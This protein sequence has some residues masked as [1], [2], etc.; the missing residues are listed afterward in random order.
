MSAGTLKE[1]QYRS[2]DDL[3]GAIQIDLSS[4]NADN[5]IEPAE[6]IKIAQRC[7]AQLGLKINKTKQTVL[8]VEHGRAKLPS[9]FY[10]LNL[11]LLCNHYNIVT[12]STSN[13]IQSHVVMISRTAPNLTSCPC[14]TVTASVVTAVPV[15]YCDRSTEVVS[16]AVGDTKLCALNID[17]SNA[18]AGT[19]SINTESFCYHDSNTGQDTCVEPT[20]CICSST[21]CICGCYKPDPWFQDKVYSICDDTIGVKVIHE[22]KNEVREYTEFSKVYMVPSKEATSFCLNSQFRDCPNQAQIRDG[23]IHLSINC[24]KI[25][26]CYEGAM[27]DED[28][29]LLVLDHPIINQFYEN[30]L[31]YQILRNLYLNGEP[32]IERR[33]QLLKEELRVSKAVAM[34]ITSTPDYREFTMAIDS[35]RS[36]MYNQFI[37]PFERRFGVFSTYGYFYNR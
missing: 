17:I 18:P 12:P 30:A 16:F 25:Y 28:G 11:A 26:I 2:F 13:G 19:I 7:N 33:L 1:L 37:H 27:E 22:C 29:N 14:W 15:T 8:D 9:D 23:F 4:Y 32:D 6:L 24:G 5:S 34:S 31:E 3:L 35:R 36:N 20:T 10:I 21:P